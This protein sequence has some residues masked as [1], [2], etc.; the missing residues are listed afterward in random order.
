M[1]SLGARESTV[2]S[3]KK[4]VSPFTRRTIQGLEDRQELREQ[5]LKKWLDDKVFKSFLLAVKQ[6]FDIFEKNNVHCKYVGLYG[7]RSIQ[8]VLNHNECEGVIEKINK[9]FEHRDFDFIILVDR[10]LAVGSSRLIPE[11]YPV[12]E[13]GGF[14]N[15]GEGP[16]LSI[17]RDGQSFQFPSLKA[18][19]KAYKGVCCGGFDLTFK[20]GDAALHY[21]KAM[22]SYWKFG[23]DFYSYIKSIERGDFQGLVRLVY[24]GDEAKS[25]VA[26][27]ICLLNAI[28]EDSSFE[29]AQK[30]AKFKA[31]NTLKKTRALIRHIVE[32]GIIGMLDNPPED[33]SSLQELD[34]QNGKIEFRPQ[35]PGGKKTQGKIKI[36]GVLARIAVD[37]LDGPIFDLQA[38][39][40]KR[41][42]MIKKQELEQEL[43][44]KQELRREQEQKQRELRESSSEGNDLPKCPG[45]SSVKQPFIKVRKNEP[46]PSSKYTR[47][48]RDGET[49][50]PARVPQCPDEDGNAKNGSCVIA[51]KILWAS[52]CCLVAYKCL[53]ESIRNSFLVLLLIQTIINL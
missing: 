43:T 32:D 46:G 49:K 8:Y 21:E 7:S 36:V 39:R 38:L 6:C 51:K 23:V 47:G 16:G 48:K 17:S 42:G 4:E 20:S 37:S 15:F 41:Q 14:S 31:A 12:F 9:F 19:D 34:S 1:I 25:C 52:F 18:T 40:L 35:K 10:P 2:L 33:V 5:L 50:S 45:V 27:P 11:L 53:P 30:A 13:K 22:K 29:S 44:R 26:S 28:F 24:Y 3:R